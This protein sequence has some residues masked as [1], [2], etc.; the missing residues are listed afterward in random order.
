[1]GPATQTA[2]V[3]LLED[4]FSSSAVAIAS[5]AA[6]S[7]EYRTTTLL[8]QSARSATMQQL[9]ELLLHVILSQ[10]PFNHTLPE[11]LREHQQ[12]FFTIWTQDHN[13]HPSSHHPTLTPAFG[14]DLLKSLRPEFQRLGEPGFQFVADLLLSCLRR[15]SPENSSRNPN[16]RGWVN[17]HSTAITVLSELLYSVPTAGWSDLDEQ[18]EHV[19]PVWKCLQYLCSGASWWSNENPVYQENIL[20]LARC[21][22]MSPP[23]FLSKRRC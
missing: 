22:C 21:V 4:I 6:V 19:A 20:K 3:E 14:L 7:A 2:L 18:A 5:D 9:G 12:R 15:L 10:P 8:L 13:F 16:I 11:L 1:M 23:L 17:V